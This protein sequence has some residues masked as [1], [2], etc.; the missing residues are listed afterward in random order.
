MILLN[1]KEVNTPWSCPI[2]NWFLSE[3]TREKSWSEFESDILDV[4]QLCLQK[5]VRRV[6]GCVILW[7]FVIVLQIIEFRYRDPVV[8]VKGEFKDGPFG[9]P[10]G[11]LNDK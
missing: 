8:E 9:V 10:A 3:E 1:G 6:D 4:W 7:T 2:Q 5:Q 11:F